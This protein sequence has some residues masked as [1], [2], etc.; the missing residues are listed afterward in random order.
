MVMAYIYF[1]AYDVRK[2]VDLDELLD[3]RANGVRVIHLLTTLKFTK[4][5]Y[6]KMESF[7]RS[8][9]ESRRWAKEGPPPEDPSTSTVR[10]AAPAAAAEPLLQQPSSPPPHTDRCSASISNRN[11]TPITS[12]QPQARHQLISLTVIGQSPSAATTT[13]SAPAPAPAPA[14]DNDLFSLDFHS[15]ST[16][17][18][19]SSS[20][21]PKKDMKQDIMSLLS[22]PAAQPNVAAS[23]VGVAGFGQLSG[24]MPGMSQ[25]GVWGNAPNPGVQTTADRKQWYRAGMEWELVLSGECMG[26]GCAYATTTAAATKFGNDMWGNSSSGIGAMGGGSQDLLGSFASSGAGTTSPAAQ[27]KDDASGDIWGGF[28]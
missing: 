8:K 27:K 5:F 12:R 7:I 19:P 25:A 16:T 21:P 22:S 28:K 24:A 17:P 3:A 14:V 10:P 9:Y 18:A 20:P 6:R 13:A 11:T 26:C 2:S 1:S 15:P 4:N 23:A